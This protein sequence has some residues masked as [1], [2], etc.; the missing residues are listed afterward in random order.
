MENV[1]GLVSLSY[2]VVFALGLAL[3][4]VICYIDWKE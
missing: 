3:G 1:S 4:I 2:V